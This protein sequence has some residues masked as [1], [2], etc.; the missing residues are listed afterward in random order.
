MTVHIATDEE[1]K[2][3][4]SAMQPA[5][6]EGFAAETGDEGRELLTLI[7]KIK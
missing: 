6:E 1:N 5:F 4:R 7:E 2:A 3:F